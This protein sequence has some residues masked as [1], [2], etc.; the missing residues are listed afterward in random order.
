[1]L[2]VGFCA[3]I[4]QIKREPEWTENQ[5]LTESKKEKHFRTEEKT[6]KSLT[7]LNLYER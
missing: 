5:E 4:T 1:L 6:T 3:S 2:S 7:I